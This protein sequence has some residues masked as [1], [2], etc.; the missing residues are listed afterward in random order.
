MQSRQ[1]THRHLAN[2]LASLSGIAWISSSFGMALA[3]VSGTFASALPSHASMVCRQEN[4]EVKP[5]T[6]TGSTET[7]ST[8]TPNDKTD[9]Q[10]P[11]TDAG[12]AFPA[13]AQSPTFGP[14]FAG[15]VQDQPAEQP[16]VKTEFGFMVPFTVTIPETK[17]QFEMIPVPGGRF[18]MG[19]PE[20][21]EGRE[22]NEGPQIEMEVPA[23][24]MAKHE[25]TW[26]EYKE[27]MRLHDVFKRFQ[28]KGIRPITDGNKMSAIAAPSNLYEPSFTYDAGD[29]PNEPAATM[30]QFSAKQY[31]K[32]LSLSTDLFFRIPTEAEWEYAC[33]AGSQTAYSFG[34]DP[35]LLAEYAWFE[36]NSDYAR[37]D[38]GEKKPNA[39]GLYD[40]HGN[41]AEWVLDQSYA[42]GFAHLEGRENLTVAS[43]FRWP[44]QWFGRVAKGG[45][46]ELSPA[47]CRCASRLVSED[48][49]R[50]SDP[51]IPRSP[52]W[53]TSYPAT[54]VGM[55]LLMPLRQPATPEGREQFWKADIQEIIDVAT[56]RATAEGRGAFGVVDK[57]LKQ[58]IEQAE[59][60]R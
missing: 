38:V 22:E 31:T 45:S 14:D 28:D 57:E 4:S 59:N 16:Y 24:W 60:D 30:S 52:Y 48:D 18:K 36:D 40:M 54:G 21:E 29:G 17:I 12:A 44:T 19:S 13:D 6:E 2:L 8:E 5:A 9:Q 20:E 58:A 43:A 46:W 35:E 47:Q 7:G 3:V 53:H 41:V 37:H 33:R 23:F 10:S 39:F 56:R 49:W 27:F 55:R 1:R 51:N 26:Q 42:D 11:T 15:L 34:D 25:V 50:N 32:W